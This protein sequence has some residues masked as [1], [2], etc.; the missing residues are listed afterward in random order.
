MRDQ[1]VCEVESMTSEQFRC[2]APTALVRLLRLSQLA[3]NP[4][5]IFPSETRQP[6]KLA[7]LDRI[8]DELVIKGGRKA[9]VWSYYVRTIEQMLHRYA[10]AGAEAIYGGVEG[11]RRIEVAERFQSP[12]GPRL[13]VANPAAAGTGFTL[14]AATYAIYETLT[15][16]YDLYAQSQDRNHRIGQTEP[17]IYL[18][19]IADDT[20]EQAIAQTLER[21]DLLARG[22]VGDAPM[23]R[24]ITEIGPEGFKQL[25]ITGQLPQ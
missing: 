11:D 18:R 24:L 15:W 17:V 5:L 7:E 16:R 14:T 23:E 25:L 1:F 3:S 20:I 12:A 2:Y 4:Q 22:L 13:L 19:L 10:A 9:I 8:V 21:K 6:G